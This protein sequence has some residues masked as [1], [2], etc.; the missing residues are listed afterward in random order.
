MFEHG[1]HHDDVGPQTWVDVVG[2][3]T[4]VEHVATDGR[5][6]CDVGVDPD[7]AADEPVPLPEHLTVG[8]PDVD[9]IVTPFDERLGA[10]EARVT[11]LAVEPAHRRSAADETGTPT[12]DHVVDDDVPDDVPHDV[13]HDVPNV[14]LVHG[15]TVPADPV[16][17]KA[18]PIIVRP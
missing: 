6:C 1:E 5:R 17:A 10:R 3:R 12:V 7:P 8:A 4:G 16:D 9:D 13:P 14:Q 2:E 11:D 18:V 15:S